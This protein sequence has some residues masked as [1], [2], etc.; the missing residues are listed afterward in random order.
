MATDGPDPK[1]CNAKIF[2]K[3]RHIFTTHSIPSNAMEKWVQNVAQE[4]NVPV[5]WHFAGGR[6][7]VLALGNK[8]EIQRAKDAVKKLMPEHDRLQRE[9]SKKGGI[10]PEQNQKIE[11]VAPHLT[12][13]SDSIDP[14]DK[15]VAPIIIGE[16][17]TPTMVIKNNEWTLKALDNLRKT[18]DFSD[19]VDAWTVI[20][21]ANIRINRLQ[22]T[23]DGIYDSEAAKKKLG[24]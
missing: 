11:F 2:K 16:P 17:R 8:E 23:L 21:A 19:K 14:P 9:E 7:C 15:I 22:D 10:K 6:A 4:A 3:G 12:P 1:P 5:D 18:L 24:L 13:P 20:S